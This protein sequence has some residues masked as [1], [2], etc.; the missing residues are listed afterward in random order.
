MNG[1]TRSPGED[2]SYEA[3]ITFRQ[4]VIMISLA[5]LGCIAVVMTMRLA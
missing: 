2:S 3:G 5:A 1:P 4:W